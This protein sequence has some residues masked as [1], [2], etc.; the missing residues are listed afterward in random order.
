MP[1]KSADTI[2]LLCFVVLE[3]G[4]GESCSSDS[5]KVDTGRRER[6]K[7]IHQN[8]VPPPTSPPPPLLLL[9]GWG[10]RQ[11]SSLPPPPAPCMHGSTY[12]IKLQTAS[13]TEL[14]DNVRTVVSSYLFL[15]GFWDRIGWCLLLHPSLTPLPPVYYV[16]A[17]PPPHELGT[18]RGRLLK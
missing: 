6:C 5:R 12:I 9:A 3:R 17:L 7:R 18:R 10:K 13:G 15:S 4:E 1:E 2:P 8:V 14:A 11:I 16:L